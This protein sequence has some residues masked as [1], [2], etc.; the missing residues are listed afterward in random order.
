MIFAQKFRELNDVCMPYCCFLKWCIQ[1]D[2]FKHFFLNTETQNCYST[3]C[4]QIHGYK[5]IKLTHRQVLNNNRTADIFVLMLECLLIF[6]RFVNAFNSHILIE[7]IVSF[8]IVLEM[9]L[10]IYFSLQRIALLFTLLSSKK[11]LLP[12]VFIR[13]RIMPTFSSTKVLFCSLQ[14]QIVFT[15]LLSPNFYCQS[16]LSALFL[17]CKARFL[18]IFGDRWWNRFSSYSQRNAVEI[19]P[20][21]ILILLY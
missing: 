6:C 12:W 5:R 15:K 1:G 21:Y 17:K 3:K 4:M 20:I 14:C 8:A 11:V 2:F 13:F 9:V 16:R 10:Y 7:I 18:V 19:L